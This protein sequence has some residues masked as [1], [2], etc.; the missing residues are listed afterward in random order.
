MLIQKKKSKENLQHLIDEF[1]DDVC[2]LFHDRLQDECDFA[3]LEISLDKIAS[4]IY[5]EVE[6]TLKAFC[7]IIENLSSDSRRIWNNCEEK[8]FDI[9]FESGNTENSFNAKIEIETI[10]RIAEI[11]ANIVI[12]IYPVLDYTIK[13]K[14]DLQKK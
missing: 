12:T 3:S 1:G 8:I 11:G 13:Q 7:S 10:K 6:E 5:G 14:E 9:G 2:I 4:G